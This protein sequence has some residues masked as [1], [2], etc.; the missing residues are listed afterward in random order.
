MEGWF[1]DRHRFSAGQFL[2]LRDACTGC[3]PAILTKSLLLAV[4]AGFV[5]ARFKNVSW[6]G[7]LAVVLFYQVVGTLAEWAYVGDLR[8]ALQDF[9]IGLP[10]M[11]LQVVGGYW[12][13]RRIMQK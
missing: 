8:L 3:F 9:R 5:A 6:K 13:L 2:A 4:A 12:V 7:L 10:G 11:L 1:A